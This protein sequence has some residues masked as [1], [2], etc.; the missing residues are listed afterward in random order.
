MRFTLLAVGVA[1]AAACAGAA[2]AHEGLVH[3]GCDPTA[4]F[5]SGG[6]T[7]SG[8]FARAML[9]NARTAGAYLTI[10]NAAG[11]PDTLLAVESIA[12]GT[13]Q[14]H[15]TVM[16]GDMA[17]MGEV[18]GGLEVPA[19]GSLSLQ[20]D[21]GFHLMFGDIRTPFKEGECV[22]LTLRFAKAGVLPVVLPVAGVAADAP[23]E[24]DHSMHDMSGAK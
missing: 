8:G 24:M 12:A 16:K 5:S 20:P 11:E 9:P 3:E 19:S 21:S 7:V 23:P 14:L 6:V 2:G 17:V 13:V 4:T 10:T 22:E 18:T 15:Q 1:I